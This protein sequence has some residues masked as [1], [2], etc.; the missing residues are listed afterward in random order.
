MNTFEQALQ[1]ELSQLKEGKN[2]RFLKS[3]PGKELLDV[4]SNDY[5]GLRDLPHLQKEFFEKHPDISL[6]PFSASS[7]RLLTGNHK[8]YLKT[9]ELLATLFQREAA[10]I[11]NSGYHANTGILSALC[12]KDDLIIADKMVHASL[13]DGFRLASCDFVRFKH[14]DFKHLENLLQRH[15]STHKCIYVVTESIFSMDGDTTDLQALLALKK[16]YG[17]ILYL[18]EAHAIGVRGDKGLGCAEEAQCLQA[19]DLIVGTFGKALASQGAYLICNQ[20]VKDFLVNKM[21]SLI[22]TTGL[23]PVNVAWTYFILKQLSDFQ[24]RRNHLQQITQNL[25]NELTKFSNF[26]VPGDS[27]IVPVVVG[28][29]EQAENLSGYLQSKGIYALPI[30]HPTVPKGTARVRFTL[31]AGMEESQ[32]NLLIE[33]LKAYEAGLE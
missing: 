32:I 9:E 16:K 3:P 5:L 33:A 8:E 10:L 12:H 17:F 14:Q 18:D 6:F 7:S 30:R 13:I 19:V 24:N 29:N 27:H 31:H 26:A 23:P 25:R 2:H 20:I 22:F 11:L 28:S 15:A 1:Q 21:R 4:S